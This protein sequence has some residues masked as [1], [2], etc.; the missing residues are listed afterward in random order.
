M[1]FFLLPPSCLNSSQ[2]TLDSNSPKDAMT[3]K[4]IKRPKDVSR[5][6]T[7]ATRLRVSPNMKLIYPLDFQLRV[8][9]TVLVDVSLPFAFR[10]QRVLAVFLVLRIK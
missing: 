9:A 5:E 1:D 3:D 6:K 8:S 10:R 2:E 7:I 4:V